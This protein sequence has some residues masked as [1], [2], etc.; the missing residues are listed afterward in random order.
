MRRQTVWHG[1]DRGARGKQRMASGFPGHIDPALL[2]RAMAAPLLSAAEEI[3]LTRLW[4]ETKD[5]SALSRLAEPHLRLV[6]SIARSF[7]HYGLPLDDLA[8]EGVLGLMHA[9]TRFDSTRGVRF[10]TYA[11]WWIRSYMT[12][13]ILRNWSLIR[14]GT[15]RS[16]KSLFFNLRKLRNEIDGI[17]INTDTMS[18]NAVDEIS[19]KLRV[20]PDDVRS[21]EQRLAGRDSSLNETF[22]EDGREERGDYLICPAP[23]PEEILLRKQTADIRSRLLDEAMECLSE[24]ERQIVQMRRLHDVPLTL[25]DIGK[26][27]GISKERVRQLETRALEKIR[28][29]ITRGKK[30]DES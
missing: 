4:Q 17:G 8:Q 22:S 30:E 29:F 20:N 3:E 5:D 11:Q 23:N 14:I 18:E 26:A 28:A 24:R 12:E 15:T 10:A 9:S 25:E 6:V 27:F 7:R 1:A 13:F 16:Q 21:M 19:R 2:R